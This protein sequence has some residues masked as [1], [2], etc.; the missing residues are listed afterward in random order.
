V[1]IGARRSELARTQAE[2]VAEALR[3]AHPGLDVECV[4]FV[5][6]GDRLRDRPLPEI[7]GKGLFTARL[8]AALTDGEIDAAV[9]SLKDLPTQIADAFE[10]AC[11]PERVDPRDVLLGPD[12]LLT[13]EELPREAVVGTSSPRRRALLRSAR[14][15]CRTRAIRGNIG[16]RVRK[17]RDGEVDALLLAA[18]GL[19]RLA[20]F[21][22][23]ELV[24]LEPPSW[25]P[26][27]GQGALA[28]EIRRDDPRS[29]EVVA[30]LED[31][32]ARAAVEAERSLLLELEG[33]CQVPIGAL[34][35]AGPGG[36]LRLDAIVVAEDGSGE[37]RASGKGSAEEASLLGASV[38]RQLLDAG[39]A[40]LLSTSAR[41]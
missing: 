11:V 9:H 13:L 24:C 2:G 14:P 40:R 33:G 18:A 36:R 41:P 10:L 30:A 8:E 23:R 34:A 1:R 32:G 12:G 4:W 37:L 25:L 29:R 5:T 38:A 19:V 28:V 35:S 15:D 16:T 3:R 6:K 7:G 22:A 26:A 31:P 39:A 20:I 21:D 17:M 27:A